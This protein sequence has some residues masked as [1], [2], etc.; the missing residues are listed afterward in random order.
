MQHELFLALAEERINA[1]LI[2][3][4]AGFPRLELFGAGVGTAA[5]VNY[6]GSVFFVFA[7]KP[8]EPTRVGEAAG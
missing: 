1:L 2:F 4:Y 8:E 7:T 3:G 5:V 6:L